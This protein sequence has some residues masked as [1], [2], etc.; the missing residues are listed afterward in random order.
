MRKE[1]KMSEL[2]LRVYLE[3]G[4]IE[5]K[6]GHE[7]DAGYDLFAPEEVMIEPGKR[8]FVD[9][10]VRML[11]PSGYAG[12]I[13]SKSGLNV[14]FDIHSNEG[15]IDAGYT[16]TIGLVIENHSS[17]VKIF[18]KGDKLTQ[19]VIFPIPSTKITLVNSLEDLGS[20]ERG[21]GGF[22]STGK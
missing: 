11:I 22:G 7:D 2:E 21:A 1:N 3:D 17:S 5:P 16:G 18:K 13:C 6:K 14:K 20:S 12:R 19:L 9:S 10:K 15:L 8:K 4:G